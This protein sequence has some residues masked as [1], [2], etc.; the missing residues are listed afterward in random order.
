MKKY[1][2]N[3]NNLDCANCARE[4]EEFL[5]KNKNFNN[6]RVN[7]NT[8]TLSY[9][10]DKNFSLDEINDL[11]QNVEPDVSV[12]EE[13]MDNKKEYINNEIDTKKREKYLLKVF[14][15][16]SIFG[17]VI[18]SIILVGNGVDHLIESYC[19]IGAD[20]L[21]I[22]TSACSSYMLNNTEKKLNELY[23][24]KI[25]LDSEN[26]NKTLNNEKI[27]KNDLSYNYD[28]DYTL[29]NDLGFSRRRRLK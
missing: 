19:L 2:Y 1:K 25:E 28:E 21:F 27:N 10:S 13:V 3:I 17:L 24:K 18:T 22:I 9:E 14:K 15:K 16:I 29:N 12:S 7:F 4:I 11:I 20:S 5:D 8:L 6:V 26:N 23:E